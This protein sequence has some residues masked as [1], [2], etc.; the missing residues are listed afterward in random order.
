M[1]TFIESTCDLINGRLTEGSQVI[2]LCDNSLKLC[3]L[4]NTK[5]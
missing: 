4:L 5:A 1:G 3:D 2:G